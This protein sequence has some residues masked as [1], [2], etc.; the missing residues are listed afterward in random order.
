PALQIT[1]RGSSGSEMASCTPRKY[2]ALLVSHCP[3]SAEASGDSWRSL[4]AHSES[5]RVGGGANTAS[6]LAISSR[7]AGEPSCLISGNRA[8]LPNWGEIRLGPWGGGDCS[9]G[10]MKLLAQQGLHFHRCPQRCQTRR[11]LG[12]NGQQARTHDASGGRPGG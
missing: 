1:T 4:S 3:G 12:R 8:C 2:S 10:G 11:E 9:E 7:S 6:V 5:V